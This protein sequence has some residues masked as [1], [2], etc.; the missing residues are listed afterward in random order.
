[1]KIFTIF[2]EEISQIRQKKKDLRNFGII[3]FA[4]F[5]VFSSIS[6]FKHGFLSFESCILS[7]IGII[8]LLLGVFL[9][10][11]LRVPHKIWMSLAIVLGYF[12]TRIILLFTYFFII[13]PM[14][15]LLQLL[16]KDLLDLQLK[17]TENTFWKDYETADD[18]E[19]YTK[20]F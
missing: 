1:M 9:P 2:L 5:E 10:F 12:F 7:A 20:M 15:L 13:T 14:R 16:G 17:K 3:F 6:F 11:T 18:K 8:F 4:A 19:R